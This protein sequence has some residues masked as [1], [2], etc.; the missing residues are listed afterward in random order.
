MSYCDLAGLSARFGEDEI[1]SLTDRA[2]TGSVD[3]TVGQQALD[4]ATE[5]INSYIA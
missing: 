5:E 2:D 3:T 1:I 4:D